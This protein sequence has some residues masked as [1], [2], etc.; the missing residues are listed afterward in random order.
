MSELIGVLA[1]IAPVLAMLVWR[2][3]RDRRRERA[4]R[5]R[6]R[7]NA[8]VNRRLG[9]ESL[10]A[11]SVTPPTSWHPGRVSLSAPADAQREIVY[12]SAAVLGLLPSHYDLVVHAAS[13]MGR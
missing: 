4:D 2:N 9:G 10:V 3:S 11:V 6:A 7:I 13:S 12:V 1:G 5:V 8:A